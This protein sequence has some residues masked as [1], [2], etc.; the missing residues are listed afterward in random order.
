VTIFNTR[1]IKRR[2]RAAAGAWF[3]PGGT[4]RRSPLPAG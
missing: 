1:V 3:S 2:S 4:F